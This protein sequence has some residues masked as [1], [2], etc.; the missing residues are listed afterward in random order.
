M[1]AKTLLPGMDLREVGKPVETRG[2]E[3]VGGPRLRRPDRNQSLVQTCWLEEVLPADHQAYEVKKTDGPGAAAWRPRMAGEEG[4]RIYSQQGSTVETVNADVKMFRGLSRMVVRG[5]RR[6]RSPVLWS[7]MA[8][9]LLYFAKEWIT[10]RPEK[11][12]IP[13][14]ATEKCPA[15]CGETR[16]SPSADNRY[17]SS[18]CLSPQEGTGILRTPAIGYESISN[19]ETRGSPEF[20]DALMAVVKVVSD[21]G[22]MFHR[23]APIFQ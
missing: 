13:G 3:A 2:N 9:N 19:S 5:L 23:G 8:Y 16:T 21:R 4:K 17:L 6:V 11:G 15:G 12:C 7:A 14:G 18:Q 10:Q 1:E 20:Q 22:T